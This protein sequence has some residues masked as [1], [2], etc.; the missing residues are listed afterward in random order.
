MRSFVLAIALG[1]GMLAAPSAHACD[2]QKQQA[3]KACDCA[4][5]SCPGMC[6]GAE[7]PKPPPPPKKKNRTS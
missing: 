5:Q 7:A 1:V 4:A 2:C 6:A 3:K